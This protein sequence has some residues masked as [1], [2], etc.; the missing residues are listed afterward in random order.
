MA[1][2]SAAPSP[3]SLLQEPG[4]FGPAGMF[5]RALPGNWGSRNPAA[6]PCGGPLR[7]IAGTGERLHSHRS[8]SRGRARKQTLITHVSC[9]TVADGSQVLHGS[10]TKD[11]FR[12]AAVA[13]P[14]VASRSLAGAVEIAV[15]GSPTQIVIGPGESMTLVVVGNGQMLP[16]HCTFTGT[17]TKL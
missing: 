3:V 6:G 1:A 9:M 13:I 17:T 11:V 7:V 14:P 15:V 5:A 2:V 10:V 4:E 8:R 12:D 16:G